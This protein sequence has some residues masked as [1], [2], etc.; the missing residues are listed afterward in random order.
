MSKMDLFINQHFRIFFRA[1][2]IVTKIDKNSL[3]FCYSKVNL[4]MNLDSFSSISIVKAKKPNFSEH[5]VV[6]LTLIY[7]PSSTS[8]SA[9]IDQLDY[10]INNSRID[11]LVRDFN[12]DALNKTSSIRLN[13][14]LI[15]YLLI[16]Q[17][18]GG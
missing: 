14:I 10:L 12:I 6:T 18:D 13:S 7:R 1:I 2:P 5:A 8:V 3:A 4:I 17:E 15:N 11:I 16:V 9:F